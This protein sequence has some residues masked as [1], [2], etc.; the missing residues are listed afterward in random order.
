MCTDK[1]KKKKRKN[2]KEKLVGS[3]KKLKKSLITKICRRASE[4]LKKMGYKQNRHQETM[5]TN[6]DN[7]HLKK[8][9]TSFLI[10]FNAAAT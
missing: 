1:K 10:S 6:L 8:N 9:Q 4:T 5:V 7:R 3:K 2:S